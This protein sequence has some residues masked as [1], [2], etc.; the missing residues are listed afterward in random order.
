MNTKIYSPELVN[1]ARVV[2]EANRAY[3]IT[4]RD[5]SQVEWDLAEDWQRGSAIAGVEATLSGAA[6]TPEE[7]HQTWCDHKIADGW[8]YGATKN[9]EAKTHPCLVPYDQ[10]PLEQRKKDVL[11]RAIVVALAG[12]G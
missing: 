2:H 6:Y 3:C 5:Y 1:I 8:V 9:A 11:F 12:E 7:Q 10:L 4:I